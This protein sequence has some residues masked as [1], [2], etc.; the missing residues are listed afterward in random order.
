[1]EA[2]RRQ[3][4]KGNVLP[5]LGMLPGASRRM[6]PGP[7]PRRPRVQASPCEPEGRAG[8]GLDARS[9]HAPVVGE[10]PPSGRSPPGA[11]TRRAA[12]A[13]LHA[14]TRLWSVRRTFACT[15]AL[16]SVSSCSPLRRPGRRESGL[17]RRP[18]CLDA[19]PRSV[20]ER[21]DHQLRRNV[22]EVRRSCRDVRLG[23][24]RAVRDGRSFVVRRSDLD[25][26]LNSLEEV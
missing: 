16:G 24:L 13:L 20:P 21:V 7:V 3:L 23:R 17:L 6:L 4:E 15:A 22:I 14:R 26:F 18:R 8:R 9:P 19:A 11:N 5:H 12:A 25:A 2:G 1:M 10:S